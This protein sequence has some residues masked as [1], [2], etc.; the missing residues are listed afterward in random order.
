MP[1]GQV[2][3]AM[4]SGAIMRWFESSKGNHVSERSIQIRVVF[5][6]NYVLYYSLYLC[7]LYCIDFKQVDPD[8]SFKAKLR[9]LTVAGSQR[10]AA[11][12]TWPV[13]G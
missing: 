9:E 11:K 7:Y 3:K 1:F 2:G 8:S 12:R 5:F 6:I 10:E 13:I 4:A